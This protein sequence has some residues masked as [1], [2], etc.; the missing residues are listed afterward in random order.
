MKRF[1]VLVSLLASAC[2]GEIGGVGENPPM[3]D[4]P[5]EPMPAPTEVRI[6]VHDPSG[7]VSGV[8]V[9][10]MNADDSVAADIVTDAQGIAVAQL[11]MGG[12]VSVIRELG[13]SPTNASAGSVYTYVGVKAGDKLDVALPTAPTGTPQTITVTLPEPDPDTGKVPVEVR[14]PCGSGQGIPPE[15]TVTLDGSCGATTD[16]YV[17]ELAGDEPAAFIKRAAVAA[18]VDLSTEMYRPALATQLSV[19][20]APTGATVYV[21]KT[22]ETDLF[23]PVFSTGMLAVAQD[24]AVEALIPDLPGVEEQLVATVSY[25]GSAQ[26]VGLRKPYA[27]APGIVDLST[28]MIIGPSA[29]TLATDTLTWTEVGT[30]MP[31]LVVGE[32]KG[33]SAHRYIVGPYAGASLRIPRLPATH[34][35]FNVSSSD[36]ISVALAKVSGGYDGVRAH[37]FAGPI[38]PLNGSATLSVATSATDAK[39]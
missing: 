16:F 1:A 20:N 14:T 17:Y 35:A 5:D 21:E 9:V 15:V 4:P 30:G 10:F 25:N 19:M 27:A 7:P 28:A 26:R 38:A 36:S 2:I 13:A 23:R 34:G 3:N 29:P 6:A 31:D 8:A 11:P 39:P 12:S 18:T 33:A 22:L 24:Q 37:V 32:L